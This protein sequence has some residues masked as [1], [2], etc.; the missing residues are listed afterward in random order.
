MTGLHKWMVLKVDAKSSVEMPTVSCRN[1]RLLTSKWMVIIS[2]VNGFRSKW[3][4]I[5][6]KNGQVVF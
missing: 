3:A 4:F 6:L 5:Q 1:A 2:G